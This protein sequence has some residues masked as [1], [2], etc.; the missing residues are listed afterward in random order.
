MTQKQLGRGGLFPS[1]RLLPLLLPLHLAA[2][3]LI[4]RDRHDLGH[5]RIEFFKRCRDRFHCLGS[6]GLSVGSTLLGLS[7]GVRQTVKALLTVRWKSIVTE[8]SF[9]ARCA[10]DGEAEAGTA[11]EQ[12]AEE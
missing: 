6:F 5:R 12:P 7:P 9:R 1:P 4:M 10:P 11:G 8:K 2:L 3:Q